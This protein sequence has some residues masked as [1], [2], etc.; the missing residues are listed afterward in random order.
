L[1]VCV[2]RLVHCPHRQVVRVDRLRARELLQHSLLVTS[3]VRASPVRLET[4][5]DRALP[6]QRPHD[7]FRGRLRLVRDARAMATRISRR[8]SLSANR[9]RRSSTITII[10]K[11]GP[12]L[13]KFLEFWRFSDAIIQL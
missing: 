9:A 12:I 1:R 6:G 7:S 3:R 8:V 2:S 10:P 13:E 4:S 11:F 5:H